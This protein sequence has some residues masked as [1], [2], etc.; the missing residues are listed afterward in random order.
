VV[1]DFIEVVA[2]DTSLDLRMEE[3]SVGEGSSL[4]G[5]KL[6][7]SQLRKQLNIIIVAIKKKDGKM[8]FNPSSE[9]EIDN[10]D[11]LIALGSQEDLLK[12]AAVGSSV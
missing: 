5:T 8:V 4:A 6:K 7:D 1:V 9:T 11:T 3:V 12:L 10:G 2:Q